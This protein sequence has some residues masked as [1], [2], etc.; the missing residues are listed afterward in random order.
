[1][2]VEFTDA[3]FK[4]LV[5]E[6]DKPVLVDFWATWG[7]PCRAIAPVIDELHNELDGKAVIGKVNID[8]NSDVP[9]EYGVRNI[10]TLLVFKNGEVVDKAVGNQ[11]KS[12]LIE[13]LT[14]HM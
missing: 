13:I 11:P 3:N 2:A 9:V 1:M 4:E 6:S 8:E 5:L 14:A 10:P 12:K 7:G